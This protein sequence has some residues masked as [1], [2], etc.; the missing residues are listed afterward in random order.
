MR[1]IVILTSEAVA[2]S[3]WKRLL[4]ESRVPLGWGGGATVACSLAKGK[5]KGLMSEMTQPPPAIWPPLCLNLTGHA[6]STGCPPGL[7]RV[8]GCRQK[9]KERDSQPCTGPSLRKQEAATTSRLQHRRP[10]CDS[11][12]VVSTLCDLEE[13]RQSLLSLEF[14]GG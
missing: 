11:S 9:R 7:E 4:S 5:G 3:T 8:L 10:G 6:G 12:S 13:W 2:P 14:L 1:V